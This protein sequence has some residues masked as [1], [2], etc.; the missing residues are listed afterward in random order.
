MKFGPHSNVQPV[1][2][3]CKNILSVFPGL[4]HVTLRRNSTTSGWEWTRITRDVG[5]SITWD[6]MESSD[7]LDGID[8]YH[9]LH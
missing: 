4:H 7:Y 9:K 8:H 3:H 2:C 1:Q 5:S 6:S